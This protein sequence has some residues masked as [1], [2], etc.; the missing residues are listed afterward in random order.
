[1]RALGDR[2]AAVVARLDQIKE[3]QFEILFEN[4]IVDELGRR[5]EDEPPAA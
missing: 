1:M 4:G 2:R 3:R 5:V